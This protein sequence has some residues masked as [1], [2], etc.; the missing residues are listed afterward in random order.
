MCRRLI[1]EGHSVVG[2]DGM[3]PYYDSSLKEVRIARLVP[4]NRFLFYRG[5]LEDKRMLE[6]AALDCEPEVIVH[7]AS[8]PRVRYSLDAPESYISSNLIGSFNVLEI[9]RKFKPSHLLLASTSSVYGSNTIM[10]LK[11]THAADWPLTIYAATKKEHEVMAHSYTHMWNIPTTVLRFFTVYGPWGRPDMA[12]FKFVDAINSDRPI[13]LYGGG[14]RRRDFTFIDDLVKSVIR[15]LGV[16]PVVGKPIVEQGV[17]DSLSPVAPFRAVNI[18]GGQPTGLF[19]FIKAIEAAMGKSAT[20]KMLSVQP[21]DVR[22]TFA[23][24]RL[25]EA[26]ISYRPNTP[27]ET[28]VVRFVALY[29]SYSEIGNAN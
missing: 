23:D 25:H 6:S 19:D 20:Y 4:F 12:L 8:Q 3:T 11:E 21:S 9:A 13:D 15:L 10:P 2:Y 29:Y 27:V 24:H 17:A 26:L 18:G 14:E 1:D 22:E 5:M 16:S 7:L 28:G